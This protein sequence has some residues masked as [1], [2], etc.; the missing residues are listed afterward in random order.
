MTS[1][2]GYSATAILAVRG[3]NDVA[4]RIFGDAHPGSADIR[5]IPHGADQSRAVRGQ[6]SHMARPIRAVPSPHDPALPKPH[7]IAH[8]R[9]AGTL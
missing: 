8:P 2:C 9:I 7:R 6:P 1:L 4:L 3:R 5:P